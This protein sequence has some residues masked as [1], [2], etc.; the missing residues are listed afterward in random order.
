MFQQ[1]EISSIRGNKDRLSDS[2]T[3]KMKGQLFLFLWQVCSPWLFKESKGQAGREC[4][5]VGEP[6]GASQ[7]TAADTTQTDTFST[8]G[9]FHLDFKESLRVDV[10]KYIS[11]FICPSLQQETSQIMSCHLTVTVGIWKYHLLSLY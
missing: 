1:A 6:W 9:G 8:S 2:T 7:P 3:G 10:K 11:V 5:K 4:R